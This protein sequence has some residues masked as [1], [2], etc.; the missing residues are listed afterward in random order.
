MHIVTTARCTHLYANECP[1]CPFD[2]RSGARAAPVGKSLTYALS[3]ICIC[4]IGILYNI[5]SSIRHGI[6]F[7][8]NK[9]PISDGKRDGKRDGGRAR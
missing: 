9:S 8:R 1:K 3:S 4:V 2:P 6:V 5:I 7:E